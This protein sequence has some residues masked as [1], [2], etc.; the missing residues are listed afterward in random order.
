M[1]TNIWTLLMSHKKSTIKQGV[2][3]N[4]QIPKYFIL[5]PTMVNNVQNYEIVKVILCTLHY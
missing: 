4:K 5:L 2:Y 3:H 1:K